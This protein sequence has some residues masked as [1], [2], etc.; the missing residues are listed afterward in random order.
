[1]KK[2]IAL[3]ALALTLTACGGDQNPKEVKKEVKQE[4]VAKEKTKEES[5]EAQE[6]EKE[7]ENDE[8]DLKI[9][10]VS[11][12]E[13]MSIKVRKLGE[14]EK[15]YTLGDIKFTIHRITCGDLTP[16]SDEIKFAFN[17][18]DTF[19]TIV[20][21]YTI[22]NTSDKT[23]SIYPGQFP[24]TTNTKEQIDGE[25]VSGVEA[26]GE[27]IGKVEKTDANFYKPQADLDEI[28]E[29]KMHIKGA[30][31]PDNPSKIEEK[32]ITFKFKD[33]GELESVE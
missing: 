24:I 26:G 9:G 17:S 32:T 7:V 23:L 12:N 30:Y 1:M 8:A 19:Q 29:I 21:G 27:M 10:E 15:E 18:E 2:L 5:K 20:I 4:E 25:F 22:E 11:E 16:K 14:I 6:V 33:N 28:N 13:D 3:M 31:D